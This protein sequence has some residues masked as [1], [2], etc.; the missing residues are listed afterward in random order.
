MIQ[1]RH[2]EEEYFSTF[3]AWQPLRG[4][5]LL[6]KKSATRRNLVRMSSMHVSANREAS[7]KSSSLPWKEGALPS[8]VYV[9]GVPTWVIGVDRKIL[10]LNPLA[11]ALLEIT[12]EEAC[13]RPCC[14]VI[15][16]HRQDEMVCGPNCLVVALR[17]QKLPVAPVTMRLGRGQRIGLEEHCVKVIYIPVDGAQ[18]G[19]PCLVCCA[20]DFDRPRRLERYML[21]VARRSRLARRLNQQR[22]HSLSIRERE[23]L[24]LLADD[25]NLKEIARTL[26]ISHSTVRNHVRNLIAK[27]GAHSIQEAIAM[28][29]LGSELST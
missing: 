16:G 11:E 13:G 5:L 27:L 12:Q 1:M 20:L 18:G 26:Y 7:G 17:N 22:P 25:H 15:R 10:F 23:V 8:W 3:R 6:S 19:G 14:D 2:F 9:L 21:K 28:F 24:Q 29:L 4:R